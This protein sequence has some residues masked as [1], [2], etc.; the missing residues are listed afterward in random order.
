MQSSLS[1]IFNVLLLSTVV[2]TLL[3]RLRHR[4][5]MTPSKEA[6]HEHKQPSVGMRD[7]GNYDDIIAVRKIDRVHSIQNSKLDSDVGLLEYEEDD[8]DALHDAPQKHVSLPNIHEPASLVIFLCAKNNRQFFGYE[9]LQTLLASGLRFGEGGL[10]HRHQHENGQGT[11]LC[12]LATATSTGVFDLE[13]IGAFSVHGLCLF[14]HVSGNVTIDE[15]R[16]TIML[17]TAKQLS[18]DLDAML[19]DDE[20]RPWSGKA[21]SRYVRLLQQG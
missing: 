12:S 3:K 15:E 20:R 16:F 8:R 5:Q 11:V 2:V 4:R 7:E 19:L 13:N 17:E 10:F 9:L 6:V 1:L 14:M 21:Q 18:D